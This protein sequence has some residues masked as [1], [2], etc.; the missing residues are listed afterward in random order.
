MD[1]SLALS[2][3]NVA[4]SW[5]IQRSNG[6]WVAGVWTE[7]NKTAIRVRGWSCPAS[8]RD[9]QMIP[10]G[11]RVS[12]MR[13]FHSRVQMY[14]S[15]ND[16]DGLGISD[17]ILYKGDQYRVVSVLQEGNRGYWKAIAAYMPG[18]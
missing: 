11:D 7:G 4:E 5:Q 14:T 1:L 18:A 2:D 9:I 15:R 16:Q 17:V 13:S 6:S 8:M 12:L 10:E 3:P